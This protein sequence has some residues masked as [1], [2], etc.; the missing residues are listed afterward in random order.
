MLDAHP[1]ED[2]KDAKGLP[3]TVRSVFIIDANRKV[4]FIA[5]YPPSA[6]RN[7][8]EFLRVT[9]SL[10]LTDNQRVTTPANWKPGDDAIVVP[11]VSDAEATK[12]FGEFTTIKPYLRTVKAENYQKKK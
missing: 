6:G 11:S 5:T 3:V 4:R 8:F 10:Q 12:L 9:D 1:D 7:F 2:Q